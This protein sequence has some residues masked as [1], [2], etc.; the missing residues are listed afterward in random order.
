MDNALREYP[1][2]LTVKE[3]KA[4]LANWPDETDTGEPIMVWVRGRA[5]A[6]HAVTGVTSTPLTPLDGPGAG[7]D[8]YL[9]TS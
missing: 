8:L 9:S 5:N 6:V 1:E 4:L 2:G 3:L 7:P